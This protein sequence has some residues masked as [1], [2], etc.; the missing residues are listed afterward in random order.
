MV[1]VAV[2]VVSVVWSAVA[3]RSGDTAFGETGCLRKRRGAP[4][5]A[6][7]Q[8]A[9]LRHKPRRFF[10]SP[11]VVFLFLHQIGKIILTA[12]IVFSGLCLH[13]EPN[14]WQRRNTNR[15]HSYREILF[16]S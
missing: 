11:S 4:L 12:F 3:E 6:A 13:R 14:R 16:G 1:I 7:V 15:R 9:R 5:P 10:P 8:D 2:V